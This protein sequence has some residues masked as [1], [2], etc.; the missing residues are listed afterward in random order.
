MQLHW[1]CL[2]FS[3]LSLDEL[4]DLLQLRDRVFVVEQDSVYGDVDGLDRQCLHVLGRDAAGALRG[5]A[6]LLPPGLKYPACAGIGRVVLDP[7]ARGTG[8]GK[9]LLR[10]ALDAALAHWPGPVRLSAQID[11]QGLYEA[12]GFVAQ[13]EPYDDG[14]ILHVDM[15]RA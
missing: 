8:L 9:A 14:G 11:K 6:R 1:Q 15:L 12:F 2:A 4:Y 13:G 7:A 10:Q 3:A 5:Y